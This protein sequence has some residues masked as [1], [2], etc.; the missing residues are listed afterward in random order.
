MTWYYE[1]KLYISI[2]SPCSST[3]TIC[4]SIE[5]THTIGTRLAKP[6]NGAERN[7]A[8]VSIKPVTWY[9]CSWLVFHLNSA[10]CIWRVGCKK[11]FNAYMR[12]LQNYKNI[13]ADVST[14]CKMYF[15]IKAY[16]RER[17]QYS[18]LMA[19][20]PMRQPFKDDNLYENTSPENQ[21]E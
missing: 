3:D 10:S 2:L 12:S 18:L 13:N 14:D 20:L 4:D 1:G 17:R 7:T 15:S 21:N 19:K 8:I 5:R 11:Q 16:L 9:T 6:T